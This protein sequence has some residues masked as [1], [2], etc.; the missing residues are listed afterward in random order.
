MMKKE[1]TITTHCEEMRAC[2]IDQDTIQRVFKICK[3]ILQYE[4]KD[5]SPS[6]KTSQTRY[7]LAPMTGECF[8][9]CLRV[10][11]CMFAG[12]GLSNG[13]YSCV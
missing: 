5:A 9:R 11:T 12:Y 4:P 3:V 2:T 7:Q 8:A 6:L 10:I 13:F 1:H